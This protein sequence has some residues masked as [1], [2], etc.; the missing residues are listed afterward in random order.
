MSSAFRIHSSEEELH[1]WQHLAFAA[2]TDAFARAQPYGIDD[3]AP[4]AH[5]AWDDALT[6]H[7]WHDDD[8]AADAFVEDLLYARQVFIA[9]WLAGYHTALVAAA[10]PHRAE[11]AYPHDERRDTHD[12]PIA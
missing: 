12:A 4:L 5:R 10:E 6:Q 2:G 3:A 1:A 7:G 11:D 9:H 8:P